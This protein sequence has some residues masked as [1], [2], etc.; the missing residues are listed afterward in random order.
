[1]QWTKKDDEE[2]LTLVNL[3]GENWKLISNHFS[4]IILNNY[5]RSKSKTNKIAL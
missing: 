4:R 5:F 3:Y 1:M 2:L